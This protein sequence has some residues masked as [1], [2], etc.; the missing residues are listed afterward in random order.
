MLATSDLFPAPCVDRVNGE[1][2]V[3]PG[4][5]VGMHSIAAAGTTPLVRLAMMWEEVPVDFV[6]AALT[7]DRTAI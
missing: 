1:I 6:T 4:F 5:G 3:P 7:A 2:V